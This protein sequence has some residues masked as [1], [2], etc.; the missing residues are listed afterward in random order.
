M[1]VARHRT[2]CLRISA[3]HDPAVRDIRPVRQGWWPRVWHMPARRRPGTAEA[4]AA[5]RM[6]LDG[7]A[8]DKDLPDIAAEV[9]A[10]HPRY[11]TFPGE[12]FLGIAA[13]AL[14]WCGAS[15]VDPVPLERMRERFLAGCS[16]RG[17]ERSRL[18]Y[19][20]L[21]AAAVSGG[22]EPDLLDEVARW[23]SDD[24]WLY[25]MYAAVAFIGLAASRAGVPVSQVC[26]ELGK[27]GAAGRAGIYGEG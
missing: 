19:A 20:A 2:G 27:A 18:Q 11:D 10:L 4:A 17:R 15:R 5:T 6:L 12:V 14:A 22:A 16:F 9:A 21:A 7:L 25:A 13:D 8:T 26:R 3:G 1:Q 23:Q 24:F